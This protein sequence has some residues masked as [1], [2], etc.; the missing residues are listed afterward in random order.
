MRFTIAVLLAV[1][2]AI[3]LTCGVAVDSTVDGP[4]LPRPVSF[5][6]EGPAAGPVPAHR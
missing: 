1:I 5:T 3:A 2:G 6:V 4:P